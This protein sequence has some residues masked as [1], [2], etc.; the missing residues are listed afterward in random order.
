M[1]EKSPTRFQQLLKVLV[2]HEVEFIVVGGVAAVLA[3]S[4]LPTIDL[5]AVY[6][7]D[8]ENLERLLGAL[9]EVGA[10]YRDPADRHIVPSVEKLATLRMSLLLTNLGAL[11]LLR[12]IGDGL[13]FQDLSGRTKEYD[14]SGLRIRALDVETLIETKEFANRPKDRNALLYL[15]QL[16]D[17]ES[18]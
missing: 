17:M 11:D 3:G 14:V 16:L 1:H 2:D 10:R 13:T 6:D 4:P 7:T 15:R 9:A 8:P 5:D 18:A 12:I